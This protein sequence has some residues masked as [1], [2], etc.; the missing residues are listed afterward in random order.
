MARDYRY[1]ADQNKKTSQ[2]SA[3]AWWK[4]LLI[5]LLISLFVFFLMLLR[6][7]APE[8]KAG[9]IAK[10]SVIPKASGR[11]KSASG[12]KNS[13]PEVPRFDFY[14]ILPETEVVIPDYEIKTRSRE[15]QFGKGKSTLYVMQVGAFREFPEADKLRAR[16]ALLG[17]ESRI[18]KANVG[19]VTWNR[20]K[21]GPFSRPSNVAALKTQLRKNN[22]D[23]IVTEVKK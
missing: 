16:L 8:P 23:V 21:I 18:E 13:K 10:N 17:I 5:M 20:V 19:S 14:T 1:R 12:E 4:W 11:L 22:I 3:V 2:Q 15:E 7:T 6:H 9:Q